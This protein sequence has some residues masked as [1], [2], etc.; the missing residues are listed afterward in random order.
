MRRDQLRKKECPP[1]PEVKKKTLYDEVRSI[2]GGKKNH[3]WMP[4]KKKLAEA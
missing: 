1:N 4:K 3:E 2:K